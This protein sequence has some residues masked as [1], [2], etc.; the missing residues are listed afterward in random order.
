M[1]QHISRKAVIAA[2]IIA[3][4]L[5]G[6]VMLPAKAGVKDAMSKAKSRLGLAKKTETSAADLRV[7]FNSLY[8]QHVH[9]ASNAVRRGFDGAADFGASAGALDKNSVW[10]SKAVGS[11]YGE[12]GE[13]RFLE[14]WKSHIGFFVDYTVAAKK[15]DKAGM[16]KAVQN[17][18][19]YQE[20][21]ADFLSK[22]N[23][24]LPYEVVKKVVGEHVGHL[25]AAVD[26]YGGG[27]FEDSY[28]NELAA[29]KQIGGIADAVS[30]AI[31]KQFPEKFGGRPVEK[32][33]KKETKMEKKIE[34]AEERMEK[35]EAKAEAKEQAKLAAAVSIK[36]FAFGPTTITVKKGTTVTWTNQ[37]G[38]KHTVTADGSEGPKSGLLAKGESTSYTFNSVGSFPYHCEPHP[39]MK[40][41]VVVT[42]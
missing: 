38:P 10:I 30:G 17:L 33:E 29:E 4:V 27:K 5:L 11:V 13:K 20:A 3:T 21:I 12:A 39:F 34:K 19:G 22:A 37:D 23:P 9:L 32:I 1:F 36:D 31:V 35:K 40:A 7:L 26:S 18:G 41:T 25:K 2:P 15:G 8:R 24:N 14:I 28:T 16:D 6:L 42:E